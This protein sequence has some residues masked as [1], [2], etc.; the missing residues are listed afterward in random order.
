VAVEPQTEQ[1]NRTR[2]L[3]D[4]FASVR[5]GDLS[6]TW[7]ARFS[8]LSR[9]GARSFAR[10]WAALPET[11][12]VDVVRR[13]DDLS[14]DRVDLNFGRAL[15]IALE[16][17]SPAVRQLAIGGLWEDESEDLRDCLRRMMRDDPSPDVR[18]EAAAALVR[19]AQRA[20]AESPSSDAARE[21]RD[22]LM[23]VALSG[24]SS[25][26]EQRRALESL[27]P[28]AAEATIAEAI[29][30]AFASGDHGLQCS[31]LRAMGLSGESHWL[32]VLLSELQSEEAELRFEAARSAGLLGS[33]DA[34]PVLLE[35][36][37]DEDAE[38]RHT[39]INAI[40]QIGGRGAVRALER[41]AE[42]AGE[43]D[44]ELIE[45]ALDEAGTML[46]PFDRAQ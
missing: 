38:V 13:F 5:S 46:E 16:D 24:A 44:Q 25:Y 2:A 37:Q 31:A 30:E 36:A 23:R 39:A 1:E 34:L 20:A 6:Q 8:D 4:A 22:E 40:G 27:G 28:F 3:A 43:A 35:A 21:L 12:R 32:P 14:E 11:V 15:R 42:D 41:L 45:A 9:D 18:S 17:P 19:F 26:A 29:R 33:V 10:E 7:L